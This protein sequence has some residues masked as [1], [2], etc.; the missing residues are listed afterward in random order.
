MKEYL[1]KRLHHIFIVKG[2]DGGTAGV[3]S[4]LVWEDNQRYSD[5]EHQTLQWIMMMEAKLCLPCPLPEHS[6]EE[7]ENLITEQ[8]ISEENNRNNYEFVKEYYASD[9]NNEETTV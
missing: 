4:E 7:I 5:P 2:Y 8:V 1:R 3:L 6:E 9:H